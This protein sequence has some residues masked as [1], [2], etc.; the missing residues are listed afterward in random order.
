MDVQM[1]MQAIFLRKEVLHLHG[2]IGTYMC[3]Q[4]FRFVVP[5]LC[6]VGIKEKQATSTE[7]PPFYCHTN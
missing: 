3:Y 2:S 6:I 5:V 1:G 4:A 7:S